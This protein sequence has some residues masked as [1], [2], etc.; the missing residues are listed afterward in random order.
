MQ[1]RLCPW[2]FFAGEIL[3]ID[4]Y[5][6][7]YNSQVAWST[8][9]VASSVNSV[10]PFNNLLFFLFLIILIRAFF[11]LCILWMIRF[12]L[13]FLWFPF[14]PWHPSNKF[15]HV[16]QFVMKDFSLYFW[17]NPSRRSLVKFPYAL[18]RVIRQQTPSESFGSGIQLLFF[19][20]LCW[21]GVLGYAYWT[22]QDPRLLVCE[23]LSLCGDDVV[24]ISW[25][26]HGSADVPSTTDLPD[27][28]S[29]VKRMHVDNTTSLSWWD[30][31]LHHQQSRIW[32]LDRYRDSPL[33]VFDDHD[34]A[35]IQSWW[36]SWVS[37]W[38]VPFWLIDRLDQ[39]LDAIARSDE[40][41]VGTRTRLRE[42]LGYVRNALIGLDHVNHSSW[43]ML[44]QEPYDWY[45]RTSLFL[46]PDSSPL[47]RSAITRLQRTI[48]LLESRWWVEW[49]SLHEDDRI[50]MVRLLE[51]VLEEIVTIVR[52]LKE[53]WDDGRVRTELLM[54]LSLLRTL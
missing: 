23:R 27:N 1:S 44:S 48:A 14:A 20:I 6:G 13:D 41:T 38:S 3:N 53:E 43:T 35:W 7:G 33:F 37:S 10:L 29:S 15:G 24:W 19:C 36:V 45:L 17:V 28:D 26:S 46:H 49:S 52:W 11:L 31:P 47:S 25:V 34:K 21:W 22:Q 16:M 4:G 2:L 18:L 9:T 5:I 39:S 42:D 51:P 40:W 30:T 50:I 32:I 54:I 8:A 12:L